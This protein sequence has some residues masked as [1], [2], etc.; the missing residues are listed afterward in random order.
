MARV[1]DRARRA[2]GR[3]RAA[4][5]RARRLPARSRRRRLCAGAVFAQA[6]SRE[7]LVDEY[8]L[9]VHPAAL[10]DGLPLFRGLPERLALAS[11]WRSR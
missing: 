10:G 6:L 7:R 5:G 11:C 8:R 9:V 3:G 2:R 4:Q 1:A